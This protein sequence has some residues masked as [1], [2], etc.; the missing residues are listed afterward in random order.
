[1]ARAC[2]G[3]VVDEPDS[4]HAQSSA[5]AALRTVTTP[6]NLHRRLG[7]LGPPVTAGAAPHFLMLCCKRFAAYSAA[8][9]LSCDGCVDELEPQHP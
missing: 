5:I 3:D 2:T 9:A 4:G 1:M 8:L 6:Q 7:R